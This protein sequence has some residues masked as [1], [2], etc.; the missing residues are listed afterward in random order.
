MAN[1]RLYIKCEQCGAWTMF[2]KHF[3]GA[4]YVH[5]RDKLVDWLDSHGGCHTNLYQTDL[6]GEP[7]FSLMTESS[8]EADR[9]D[10]ALQNSLGDTP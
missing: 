2:M 9:L 5:D 7:G 4:L 10:P 6:G 1:D 8:P 3:T